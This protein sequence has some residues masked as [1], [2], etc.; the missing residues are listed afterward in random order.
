MQMKIAVVGPSPVPFTIGGAENLLWGLCDAINKKT[1]HQAE[2]IKLPSRELDFWSLVQTYYDFYNLN[3]DQFDLVISTK[4]PSWMVQHRNCIC[5]MV[6]TLRGLYDT[7]HLMNQPTVVDRKNPHINKVLEYME[8][9]KE[10]ADLDEFFKLIFSLKDRKDISENYFVFPGPFIRL[11]IHY[12]D[13]V[14]LSQEGM[15]RICAISETVKYR[16]EYY[17]QGSKVDVIYPPTILKK[18]NSGQMKHIFI[19]SR[20][21]AAKRIDLLIR[22]MEYVKGDVQLYIAGNGPQREEWEK[23]AKKD[24]RIHFLGFVDEDVLEDYYSNSLVIPYFPYDEDYGLITIEAMLHKKP[25]ITTKDA[26]GPTEFVVDGETGYVTKVDTRAIAEKVNFLI[27]HPEEARRMGENAYQKVKNIT[28]SN[29]VNDLLENYI[30][31]QRGTVKKKLSEK[32]SSNVCDG[33]NITVASTFPIYPPQGGGQART[34]NLYKQLAR[35]E[36]VTIVSFTNADQKKYEG[37]IASNVREVRIP[38]TIRHQELE[39]KM[40]EKAELPIGD[41]GMITLSGYTSEY[42]QQ[43]KKSIEKSDIVILS[44]PYLFNLAKKYL[45]EKLL[46]YEAQDVEILIKEKMIPDTSIKK[47]LLQQIFEIEKECCEKSQFIMTCSKEDQ[48]SLNKIYNVPFEKMIEIPNGVDC[49]DICFTPVSERIA[50][51]RKLTL[52]DEKLGIFMGSWHQPNLEA[53]EKIFDI[54]RECPNTKF[55]LMGSQCEYFRK[56]SLPSNVGLLGLVSEETKARVFSTVDFALNPM[57]SG[58]GTNLKMFDYMASG[59]PIITTNFGTRGIEDKSGFI[60]AEIG[61]IPQVI[62]RFEL[63]KMVQKVEFSR[64]YA[65]NHYDW[66]IISDILQERIQDEFK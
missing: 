60:V 56:K 8:H 16:K 59:I 57:L 39:Q 42:E 31:E 54:A 48:V 36:N 43:L 7:Y 30:M 33:R 17:P 35:K 66:K 12:L 1:E 53:C 65:E 13:C 11:I 24:G 32:E 51:K 61:E 55:L 44:H 63:N 4:Y 64:K 6:H 20:L 47:Q 2:L 49:S 15:K 29:V 28:W 34:Y 52:Q 19:A 46:I 37:Y 9:K 3:L 10:M 50:N 40:E 18:R 26:G 14:A 27:E 22:A 5:Y 21:D 41:I 58:S 62:N 45:N 38:K 25:V 23:L